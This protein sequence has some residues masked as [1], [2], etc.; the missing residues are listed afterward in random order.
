MKWTEDKINIVKEMLIKGCTYAQIAKEIGGTVKSLGNF[1]SRY[2]IKKRELSTTILTKTCI[3]CGKKF[4]VT[5]TSDKRFN[6]KFCSHS[7]SAI[8]NNKLRHKK[9]KKK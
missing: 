2:K 8:Y 9:V 5:K 4:T 6:H 3:Q 1:L 7:C